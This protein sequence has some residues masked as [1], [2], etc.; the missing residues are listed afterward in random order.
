MAPNGKEYYGEEYEYYGEEYYILEALWYNVMGDKKAFWGIEFSELQKEL[1]WM[2]LSDFRV[3]RK[4][5][6]NNNL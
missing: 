5:Y 2:I 3:L 1:Q 4:K 6:I